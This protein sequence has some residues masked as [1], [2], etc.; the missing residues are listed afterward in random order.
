MNP[1]LDLT[2]SLSPSFYRSLECELFMQLPVLGFVHSFCFSSM[3]CFFLKKKWCLVFRKT[4]E[5]PA[6][7][8]RFIFLLMEHD[9]V[10]FFLGCS[11]PEQGQESG[12]CENN[13]KNRAN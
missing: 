13:N 1:A 10:T 8:F 4:S 9:P 5:L 7:K 12:A 3:L 6:L 11:E 2:L